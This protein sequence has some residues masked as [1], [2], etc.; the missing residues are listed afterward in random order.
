MA[1]VGIFGA[2]KMPVILYR[3][4]E[5]GTAT[6]GYFRVIRDFQAPKIKGQLA[7]RAWRAGEAFRSDVRHFTHDPSVIR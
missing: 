3:T 6:C 2:E 7:P 4:R 5:I 1:M